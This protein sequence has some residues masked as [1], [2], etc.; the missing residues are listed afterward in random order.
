MKV[1]PC[2]LILA[3]WIFVPLSARA[4][5]YLFDDMPPPDEASELPTPFTQFSGIDGKISLDK[6]SPEPFISDAA[7]SVQPRFYYR[8]VR[9]ALGV[10]DTFAGGGS[11][12]LTTGWWRDAVQFGVTGYMTQPLVAVKENNR[13]GLVES[14][15]SGFFTL[16]QAWARVRV[17]PAKATVFRQILSLPFINAND[18]RMIP[19]TFEAYQVEATLGDFVRLNAG[20]ITQMKAR[21]SPDFVSM[22]EAAGAPQVDRGTSFFGI[23]ASKEDGP[24]LGLENETTWDLFTSTYLQAGHTWQVT[25]G[26]QLRGDLQFVDQRSVGGEYVGTFDSQLYGARVASSYGGA[27]LSFSYTGV[28]GTSG[29]FSPYGADPGFNRVMISNFARK[30][31]QAI[32]TSLSYD[33]SRIGLRGVT[34]FASY[35]YGVLP[36]DQWE[37]EFNVTCDYRINAGLLKNVWLRLRYAHNEMSGQVPIEDFRVILNYAVTF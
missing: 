36:D 27:V 15:G 24:Y 6:L 17:G 18:A 37:H 30:S 9:N 8:S 33:F 1:L 4:Q 13:S 35:I 22:S 23:M 3:L 2:F 20:Y 26:L 31:E 14:D 34:A 21:N 25:S 32:G 19:N 11:M 29:L 28:G 10:Q 7:L 5:E 16:G 12:G